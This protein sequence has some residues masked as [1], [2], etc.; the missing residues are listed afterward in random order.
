M[1]TINQQAIVIGASM[2]GL[3]AAR[4]LAD[5]YQRYRVV[6]IAFLKVT[7]LMA[8][9]YSVMHPRISLSGAIG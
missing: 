7:N 5:Y 6:A 2:G 9:P 4:A 1:K 8:S 3:L